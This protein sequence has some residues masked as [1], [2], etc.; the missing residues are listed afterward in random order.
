MARRRQGV[1]AELD[2]LSGELLAR[3]LDLLAEGADVNVLL[4][5]EDEQR[6]VASYELADDSPEQLLAAAH[7]RVLELARAHGDTTCLLGEPVRY[8]LV[9][10]GAIELEGRYQDALILE[11]GERGYQAYSAYLLVRGKGTGDGLSWTDPAPAGEVES[12]L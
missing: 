6:H 9:Y 10:E 11:F 12:L 3:A 4:V 2:E 5:I 1:T 7:G 8:A